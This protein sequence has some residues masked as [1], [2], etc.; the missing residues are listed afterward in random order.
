M[1]YFRDILF[2][3]RELWLIALFN[4]LAVYA[5]FSSSQGQDVLLC[6]VE[7]WSKALWA[8]YL[9]L[10]I[11]LIFWSISTYF[12]TKFIIMMT[13]NSS[14]TL[15]QFRIAFRKKIQ[16]FLVQLSLHLPSIIMICGF[17]RLFSSNKELGS[18]IYF[19]IIG[20]LVINIITFFSLRSCLNSKNHSSLAKFFQIFTHEFD[21]LTG[22]F[23][24]IR[25]SIPK[26][27]GRNKEL[28]FKEYINQLS[29]SDIQN[30]KIE[31]LKIEGDYHEEGDRNYVMVRRKYIYYFKLFN[32]YYL[33]LLLSLA[34]IIWGSFI[35]N[36]KS[37]YTIGST[38]IICLAFGIWQIVYLGIHILE[39][40]RP[41]SFSIPYRFVVFIW[42]LFCTYFNWDH[43]V[44]VVST[45]GYV[46]S[47][48][49]LNEH[50]KKW[51]TQMKD[52]TT[53]NYNGKRRI[54]VFFIAAEGGALRSGAFTATTLA[55]IQEKYGQF[56]DHLFIMSGVSGGAVGLAYNY[57]LQKQVSNSNPSKWT[58]DFFSKDMLAYV[59]VKMVLSEVAGYFLPLYIEK[60]DRAVALDQAMEMAYKESRGGENFF[61][62]PFLSNPA[63]LR[64]PALFLNTTE[65]ETGNQCYISNVRIKY[66]DTFDQSFFKP[67]DILSNINGHIKFSTAVNF[68]SRFPLVSPSA[69]LF[70]KKNCKDY[71]RH[72]VDGGYFEN[73]ASYTLLKILKYLEKSEP[74]AFDRII[75]VVIQFNFG[76][77]NE[78]IDVKNGNSWF[79]EFA[80]PIIAIYKV[81]SSKTDLSRLELREFLN[82]YSQP[83]YIAVNN[84][85][86]ERNLPMNWVLSYKSINRL[87]NSVD[88]LIHHNTIV[89]MKSL[90]L[91][92]YYLNDK[93]KL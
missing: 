2:V 30:V 91:L 82:K 55:K 60:F 37:A 27:D 62:K 52:S 67:R 47:R 36:P 3:L 29:S 86:E 7:D 41:F 40:Y 68:S 42:L 19:I 72:Y 54:P 9:S 11:A 4:L 22:Y 90:S 44:K 88:T 73:S 38:A 83:N 34:I 69:C 79:N 71:K 48:P 45:S 51:L 53:I 89:K 50:F 76:D 21:V 81:R 65:V 6:L 20:L 17:L 61:Q 63:N 18:A 39:R 13:D 12:T 66:K 1:K 24:P 5:F 80:D 33:L 16:R 25:I 92:N 77:D 84:I 32:W 26:K 15:P 93:N 87:N 35:A 28:F 8:T 78:P 56:N 70:F 59:T 14:T 31:H 85:I 64:F 23:S 58:K 74:E 43:P 57:T 49:F 10:L 46:D 75:P